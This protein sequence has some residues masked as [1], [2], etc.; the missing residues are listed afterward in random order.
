MRSQAPRG[1]R[2]TIKKQM[3]TG[4][5]KILKKIQPNVKEWGKHMGDI[6]DHLDDYEDDGDD[7]GVDD[8]MIE[9]KHCG[10]DGLY[11][12]EARDEQRNWRY[13]LMNGKTGE[14]HNCPAFQP[15][16]PPSSADDFETVD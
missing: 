5:G 4:H 8:G 16:A 7:Y 10:E 12:E 6:R 11:W 3:S 9:C 15:K 13:V 1:Q 14:I 2:V